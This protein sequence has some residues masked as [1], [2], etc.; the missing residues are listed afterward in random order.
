M[1][2]QLASWY[3]MLPRSELENLARVAME[4]ASRNLSAM[5]GRTISIDTQRVRTIP[6]EEVAAYAGDPNTEMAAAYLQIEGDQHGQALVLQSVPSA[7][8]LVDLLMGMPVGTTDSLGEMEHAALGEAGNVVVAGFL[9]A[10]VAVTGGQL[11]L[12]PPSV[13]V[14][15]LE[16][17]IDVIASTAKD[18]SHDLLII[19]AALKDDDRAVEAHLWVL[20]DPATET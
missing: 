3:S 12:T 14:D 6:L 2:E 19:D 18:G 11:L 4:G 8:R 13:I 5:V 17:I 16:A 9:N 10:M 20:P 7:L 15:K 1:N